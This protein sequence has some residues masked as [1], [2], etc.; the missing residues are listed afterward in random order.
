LVA[1]V[2]RLCGIRS[3]LSGRPRSTSKVQ[4]KICLAR[5][6]QREYPIAWTR[7]GGV[8]PLHL[9]FRVLMVEVKL[10][11]APFCDALSGLGLRRNPP[12]GY[13]G[14]HILGY[15]LAAFQGFLIFVSECAVVE[16]KLV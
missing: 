2:P 9:S 6:D 14:P 5:L 15:S 16:V 7:G 12:S 10:A 4:Q 1:I 11:S 3:S 8:T 13:P